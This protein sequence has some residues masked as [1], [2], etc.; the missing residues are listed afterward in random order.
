MVSAEQ[1]RRRFG[2]DRE[3]RRRREPRW[4]DPDARMTGAA[5]CVVRS[6]VRAQLWEA[7]LPADRPRPSVHPRAS[8]HPERFVSRH[9][10]ES[11]SVR[12]S[13]LANSSRTKNSSYRFP[14]H[15]PCCGNDQPNQQRPRCYPP[16]QREQVV[17]AS[18]PS[19]S[20][21]IPRRKRYRR[22]HRGAG[23]R[24]ICGKLSQ[25]MRTGTAEQVPPPGRS[26]G[27]T[28]RMACGFVSA[29][30]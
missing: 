7:A 11:P 18:A 16:Q 21:D 24:S 12:F 19:S 13:P 6:G 22:S 8:E 5:Q 10:R 27:L 28:R 15:E 30:P 3:A 1:I 20:A 29:E 2:I 23:R 4:A 17:D 9:S 26:A 25:D 14:L